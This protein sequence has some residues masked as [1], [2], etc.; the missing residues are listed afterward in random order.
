M[1]IILRASLL[2]A[3]ILLTTVSISATSSPLPNNHNHH[4]KDVSL[5][6]D[7]SKLRQRERIPGSVDNDSNSDSDDESSVNKG[8]PTGNNRKDGVTNQHDDAVFGN[9][10]SEH[11]HDVKDYLAKKTLDRKLKQSVQKPTKPN[12]NIK[13]VFGKLSFVRKKQ[14][15]YIDI[16]NF[17]PEQDDTAPSSSDDES[18]DYQP[19]HFKQD[20][21]ELQALKYHL[22]TQMP[23]T[24][25]PPNDIILSP[26][27]VALRAAVS[28]LD[29]ALA[30][31]EYEENRKEYMKLSKDDAA[32]YM[33][34]VEV[35]ETSPFINRDD[36]S[37]D[38]DDEDKPLPSTNKKEPNKLKK[39]KK[40]LRKRY[41]RYRGDTDYHFRNFPH[42]FFE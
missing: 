5:T 30:R 27:S 31:L 2:L 18:L 37:S 13:R 19:E 24:P 16:G 34:D 7:S 33:E 29:K 22:L 14:V 23:S 11:E 42:S 35:W 17:F 1:I 32:V 41:P 21:A 8:N 40:S 36:D 39:K 38:S 25:L 20:R 4:I 28:G 26:H 10:D 12:S 6:N 3:I 15:S 9:D